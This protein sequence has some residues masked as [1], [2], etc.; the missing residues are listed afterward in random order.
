MTEVADP[1][2]LWGLDGSIILYG[3]LADIFLIVPLILYLVLDD[4]NAWA[5]YHQTYINM[6]FSAYAP[7]G[8]TWF[9]VLADDSATARVAM[10]GA[11]EMAGLG[12]YALLWVGY[13]TFLMSA[14]SGLA[15]VT[16]NTM[17]WIFAI[18]YPIVNILLIILHYHLSPPMYAW[19]QAAPRLRNDIDYPKPWSAPSG[20]VAVVEEPAEEPEDDVDASVNL[21]AD[22]DASVDADV[23]ADADVETD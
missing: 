15:L 14:K 13:A 8:I 1:N 3:V 6:I 9:I 23:E 11:I 12:P 10:Q 20:A 18:I 2:V 7:L 21:N 22:V 5:Q 17:V 4:A 16:A 19:L